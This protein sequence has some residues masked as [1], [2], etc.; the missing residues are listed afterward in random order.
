MDGSW[1]ARLLPLWRRRER[2]PASSYAATLT[3]LLVQRR[4]D[5]RGTTSEAIR[6]S[7]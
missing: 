1:V 5:V 3:E 4:L 7:A 2:R 6:P